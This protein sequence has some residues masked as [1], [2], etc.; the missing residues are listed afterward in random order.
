VVDINNHTLK[1]YIEHN[2]Y[3]CAIL[4]DVLYFATAASSFQAHNLNTGKKVLDFNLR[5]ETQFGVATY[6][7]AKGK[8]FVVV[9]DKGYTYCFEG[10]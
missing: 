2:I 3:P 9:G 6:K 1:F 8:K 10:V 5:W 4:D 7:N